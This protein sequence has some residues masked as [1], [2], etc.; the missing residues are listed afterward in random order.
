MNSV[1]FLIFPFI[2]LGGIIAFLGTI[3]WIWMVIDCAMNESNEGN[4]KI[5]WIII[6]LLTNVLGAIIYF[7]FRRPQR[8]AQLGR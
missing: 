1:P 5:V 7:L 8:K 6:I 4:D 3:F 2:F